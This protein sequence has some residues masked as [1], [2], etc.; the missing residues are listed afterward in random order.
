MIMMDFL[1][2]RNMAGRNVWTMSDASHSLLKKMSML[3]LR[4]TMKSG[5][6][7]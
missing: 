3:S 7:N 5:I 4:D 1:F 2:L 6:R